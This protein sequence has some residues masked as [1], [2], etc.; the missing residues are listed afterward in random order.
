MRLRKTFHGAR[1]KTGARSGG[2]SGAKAARALPLPLAD[3]H[4]P[5]AGARFGVGFAALCGFV[6]PDGA[7]LAAPA[8][9]QLAAGYRRCDNCLTAWI[10]APQL[11]N[12]AA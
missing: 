1:R 5:A 8:D 4:I 3:V 2:A 7:Y 10:R 11:A 9:V 12:G 6:S